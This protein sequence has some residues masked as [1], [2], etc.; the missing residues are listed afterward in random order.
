MTQSA[1]RKRLS[2]RT[3]Y[4]AKQYFIN[5]EFKRGPKKQTKQN[6]KESVTSRSALGEKKT[7]KDEMKGHLESN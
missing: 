3:Q 1:N 7:L 6:L 5:E 2:T 4:P